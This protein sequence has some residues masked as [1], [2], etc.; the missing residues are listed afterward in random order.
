MTA[1]I[2]Q[3]GDHGVWSA[4]FRGA[5]GNGHIREAVTEIESLGVGTLWLPAGAGG[6][7]LEDVRALLETTRSMVVATGILNVWQHDPTDVARHQSEFEESFP[8]RFLLGLGVGH[9]A[10]VDAQRPGTYRRPLTKMRHYLD[11]L[12]HS[13]GAAPMDRRVLAALGPRMLA[14]ARER[15]GGTLTFLAPVEHT[16]LARRRL[17]AGALVAVELAVLLETDPVRARALARTHLATALPLPN[18]ADNLHRCG[19][20]DDDLRDG[21]SDRLV[22]AVVAWGDEAEIRGRIEAHRAAGADH[23]CSNPIGEQD[24]HTRPAW[25]D[26]LRT[27]GG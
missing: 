16:R 15:A 22:D 21:G 1:V 7:L 8:G 24:L 18:Y 14:L 2:P 4:A 26:L 3:L 27:V 17:G 9:A 23:V 13:P 25:R 10:L 5:A 19:F 11:A 20:T 6:P 12:D